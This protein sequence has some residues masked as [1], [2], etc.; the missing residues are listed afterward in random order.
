MDK[1]IKI[2]GLQHISEDILKL[3]DK[4]ILI[5]CRLVNSSW[6]T[7]LE[8][9]RFWLKKFKLEKLPLDGQ[10]SL[11]ALVKKLEDDQMAK[12]SA[13][14]LLE[15]FNL[16]N[17]LSGL[18]QRLRND[19]LSKEFVLLMIKIYKGKEN[20]LLKIAVR[21]K[22]GY[23]YPIIPNELKISRNSLMDTNKYQELIK[24]IIKHENLNSKLN[25]T[26]SIFSGKHG[27]KSFF[28]E[29]ATPIHLAVL[30]GF[31]D[32]FEKLNNKRLRPLDG[33]SAI[34]VPASRFGCCFE[35]A[36][37]GGHLNTLKYLVKI[38]DTSIAPVQK[39]GGVLY[40]C[41][42]ISAAAEMGH[43]DIVKYF[44][45]TFSTSVLFPRG[46]TQMTAIIYNARSGYLEVAKYLEEHCK[47]TFRV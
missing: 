46:R 9:P 26:V 43:L 24:F 3:L 33:W 4:N 47:N 16:E 39:C 42:P 45:D 11:K 13:N 6:K 28:V 2:P 27:G 8:Q 38:T 20:N 25:L 12:N 37:M 7:V 10:E 23:T 31:T 18:A 5:E 17:K 41:C 1:F 44:V 15:N 36:A 34:S 32:V 30:F 22:G 14:D 40:W 35:L 29:H 19:E 21:L